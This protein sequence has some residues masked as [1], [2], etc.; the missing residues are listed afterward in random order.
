MNELDDLKQTWKTLSESQVQKEYTHQELLLIVK[1]KSNNELL[2]MRQKLLIEWSLAIFLALLL[3]IYI[4]WLNPA[5]TLFVGLFLL[6]ILVVSFVPYLKL[7]K[8]K[9]AHYTDLRSHLHEL[10]N[11]YDKMVAQY[12]HLSFVT[13][14]IGVLGGFA[15]GYHSNGSTY[16]WDDLFEWPKFL[17]LVL[18]LS[19]V[20]FGGCYLQKKYFSWFYGKNLDRIKK[21]LAELEKAED[22]NIE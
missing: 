2:K 14:P 19:G 12:T 17:I 22:E 8:L 3:V 16:G 18:I 11:R 9:I 7:V 1:R 10:I 5:D 21:C 6:V 13:I 20:A 4:G 15:L